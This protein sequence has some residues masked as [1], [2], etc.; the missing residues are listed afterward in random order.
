MSSDVEALKKQAMLLDYG[1]LQ[2]IRKTAD[3]KK[4]E[5]LEQAAD[6]IEHQVMEWLNT[7]L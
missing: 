4:I 7:A 6:V 3:K 1:I 2:V 5:A